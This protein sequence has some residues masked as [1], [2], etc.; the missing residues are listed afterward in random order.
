MSYAWQQPYPVRTT[1]PVSLHVVAIFQYLG[2][3]ITLAIG[4]LLALAAVDVIPR[5]EYATGNDAWTTRPAQITPIVAV[6]CGSFIIVG[7]IAIM[8]GRKLQRGRNW[9][10]VL[11]TALNLLSVAGGVWQGYTTGRPYA[12]TLISIVLPLVFVFLLNTR[13]ARSWCRYQT[14]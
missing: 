9:A 5:L 14:Y 6:I 12:E 4:A 2:G 11:L 1:A 7:L 10:R 13:A 8:L 3:L